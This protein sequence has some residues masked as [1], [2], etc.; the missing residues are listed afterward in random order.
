M[1]AVDTGSFT[2][3]F[4]NEHIIHENHK[5]ASVDIATRPL[6]MRIEVPDYDKYYDFIKSNMVMFNQ[7]YLDK[8]AKKYL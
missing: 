8:Y 3:S 6:E 1:P 4:K 2:V 5:L 7:E